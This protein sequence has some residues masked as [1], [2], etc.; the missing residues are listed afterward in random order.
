MS[1]IHGEWAEASRA[2]FDAV[3]SN[4]W[5]YSVCRLVAFHDYCESASRWRVALIVCLYYAPALAALIVFDDPQEGWSANTIFWARYYIGAG[6]VSAAVLQESHIV[7][8]EIHF[9]TRKIVLIIFGVSVGYT[10]SLMLIAELWMF[11]I[12][13]IY[14]VS[15]VPFIFIMNT[16]VT[17][18]LGAANKEHFAK[19]VKFTNLLSVQTMMLIV[20]ST[21][22]AIFLSIE[23]VSRLAFVLLLPGIK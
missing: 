3:Q 2:L 4:R 11:P 14:T 5:T 23:R 17:L 21:Y 19:F 13:F 16:L 6:I 8:P 18:A 7:I 10:A 15:G 22:N 12:P 9:T 1:R 20:H